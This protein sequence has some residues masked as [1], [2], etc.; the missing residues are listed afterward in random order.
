[1]TKKPDPYKIY[2]ICLYIGNTVQ[3]NHDFFS[4]TRHF[5]KMSSDVVKSTGCVRGSPLFRC[6]AH[7]YKNKV[8]AIHLTTHTHCHPCLN[9]H[10]QS[11][12]ITPMD[13]LICKHRIMIKDHEKHTGGTYWPISTTNMNVLSLVLNDCMP[14]QIF[15]SV[16]GIDF[17]LCDLI[18]WTSEAKWN[19]DYIFCIARQSGNKRSD[20]R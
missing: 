9:M 16:W 14:G 12:F 5:N 20:T 19:T 7:Q 11:C 4:K 1:M 2:F 13:R 10:Q 15:S 6:Q 3:N 8:S 17:V 18:T